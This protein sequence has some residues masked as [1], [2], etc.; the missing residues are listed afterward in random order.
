MGWVNVTGNR[1]KW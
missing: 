1:R